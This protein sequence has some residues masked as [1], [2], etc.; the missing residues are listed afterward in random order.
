MN[1]LVIFIYFAITSTFADRCSEEDTLFAVKKPIYD[2]SVS[3]LERVAQDAESHFVFSPLA[4]W[5]QLVTLA[6]GARGRSLQEIWNVTG[7]TGY[8]K[9]TCYRQKFRQILN[10]FEDEV[11]NNA[12]RKSVVAVDKFYKVKDSFKRRIEA[13]NNVNVLSLDFDQPDKSIDKIEAILQEVNLEDNNKD[14]EQVLPYVYDDDFDRSVFLMY[15]AAYLKVAWKYG[16]DKTQT[17]LAPFYYDSPV[18][19]GS[20]FMMNQ[21][22]QFKEIELPSINARVLELPCENER[23]SMF[24]LL[25]LTGIISD[26]YYSLKKTS[27]TGI[28]T[29]LE[30]EQPKTM[31]VSLPAFELD[32]EITN[33]VELL[34]DMGVK[35][36]FYPETAELTKMTN[37]GRISVSYMYQMATIQVNESHVKARVENLVADA[38]VEFNANKPFAFMLVDKKTELILFAGM[39]SKPDDEGFVNE[40]DLQQTLSEDKWDENDENYIFPETNDVKMDSEDIF[41]PQYDIKSKPAT[42]DVKIGKNSIIPVKL[43]TNSKFNYGFYNKNKD[44]DEVSTKPSVDFESKDEETH[45]DDDL[46]LYS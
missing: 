33:V 27:L 10:H 4:T 19:V 12:K 37:S 1:T 44:F 21:I 13:L 38:A 23:L 2:F 34:Y 26:M 24:I 43:D 45:Y 28:L 40:I 18:V 32:T 42:T 3:L 6:E 15:D 31:N 14:T 36:V 39:Y 35:S 8:R 30:M 7:L 46:D 9:K 22:G 29:K 17:K 5:L 25:P 41:P 16:F 20:V 11:A